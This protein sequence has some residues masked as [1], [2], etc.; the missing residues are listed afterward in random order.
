M[1]LLLLD[2]INDDVTDTFLEKDMPDLYI[3][4]MWHNDLQYTMMG[5]TSLE[6]SLLKHLYS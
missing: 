1:V 5:D 3:I 6:R 2:K 4:Y